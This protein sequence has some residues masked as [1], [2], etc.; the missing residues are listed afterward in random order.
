[1]NSNF[2]FFKLCMIM[3]SIAP[4][5]YCVEKVSCTRLSVKIA[6]ISGL[7][8]HTVWCK[9]KW[10]LTIWFC[11]SPWT[12]TA[13]FCVNPKLLDC[14]TDSFDNYI[15]WLLVKVTLCA[16][17]RMYVM[18]TNIQKQ[19]NKHYK[20]YVRQTFLI[21]T[22][23]LSYSK[24][25][26]FKNIIKCI[27]ASRRV[28]GNFDISQTMVIVKIQMLSAWPTTVWSILLFTSSKALHSLFN[29]RSWFRS[30]IVE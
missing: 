11:A 19:N 10:T 13:E 18:R 20:M 4:I 30:R 2:N 9:S 28:L 24:I 29:L 6:P 25:L 23:Q 12:L 27:K 7:E 26:Q 16:C 21:Y 8:F 3:C 14:F 5:D 1:M 22:S 17:I 15:H